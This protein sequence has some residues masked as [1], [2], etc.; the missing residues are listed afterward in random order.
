MIRLWDTIVDKGI[1]GLL[2]PWQTRRTDRAA[3]DGVRYELLALAQAEQDLKDIRAG[4]KTLRAATGPPP[5]VLMWLG[6]ARI[7]GR[8]N[9]ARLWA[10]SQRGLRYAG[11]PAKH[12]SRSWL[13]E[14]SHCHRR[15]VGARGCP[16]RPDRI[17][18][19]RGT[20]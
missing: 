7:C 12:K 10:S 2:A 3:A 6:A 16:L 14:L 8:Y 1:S 17:Q 4:R 11:L 20:G 13:T 18:H 15:S 5:H 9:A 19:H